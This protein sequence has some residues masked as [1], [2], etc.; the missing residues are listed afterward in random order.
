MILNNKISENIVSLIGNTPL[1]RLNGASEETNCN[2][3]GKAEFMNPGQSIKDRA[4]LRMI[5]NAEKNNL[6]SKGGLIVEGTGGNTGIGLTV[7]ANSLGYKTL[8]VMPE[9]QSYEKIQMLKQLGANVILTKVVP[10]TEPDNYIKKAESISIQKNALWTNQF[11]N[12]SN[13][14]SHFYG[15]AQEIWKQTDGTIDA[16]ICS[17]GTGGT[18]SGNSMALKEKNKNIKVYCADPFGSGMYSWIKTGRPEATGESIIEGIGQSRITKNIE[19]TIIDGA[20]Q[21]SDREALRVMYKTLQQEGLFLGPTSG[22]NIAGAIKL[23]KDI[24]P[25]KTIVTVL[26]DYGNKY[27]SKVFNKQYLIEKNLPVPEWI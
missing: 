1:L 26:C 19:G 17:V 15:T 7:I 5:Q 10:F 20:Y 8:I 22:L 4:A 18:L 24:G 6:I 2:I 13:R 3:L 27:V 16:F 25:N 12:L 14:D 11:D 21:I 23:A 9:N